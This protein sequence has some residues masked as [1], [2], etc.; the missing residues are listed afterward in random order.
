MTPCPAP[1]QN[2]NSRFNPDKEK[3]IARYVAFKQEVKLR[4]I[5]I[6]E[7]NT[8]IVFYFKMPKSWTK[9]KKDSLR[10]KAHQQVPDLD[11]LL[12]A[13]LDAVHEQDCRVWDYRA[14]K[15]WCDRDGIEVTSL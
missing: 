6:P 11:N 13:L 9:K 10:G 3:A 14:R 7:S 15:L 12:K 1:R 8:L 4:K 2:K 5:H